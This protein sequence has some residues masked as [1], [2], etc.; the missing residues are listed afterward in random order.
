MVCPNYYPVTCGVGDY[1]MRL[2]QELIDR[3]AEVAVF[4][5]TPAARNPECPAVDVF[6]A[7]GRT[8]L[9]VTMGLY[10]SI[11]AFDPTDL[12]IQ[13]TPHMLR[14]SRFGTLALPA[15]MGQFRG[16]ARRTVIFHELYM[17]WS[18]RPD[19]AVGGVLQR[20]QFGAVLG[21]ADRMFVTTVPRQRHVEGLLRQARRDRDVEVLY[22]GANAPPLPP[23]PSP[24]VRRLGIFSMMGMNRRFDLMVEAFALVKQHHPNGELV[25]IGNLGDDASPLYRTLRGQIARSP[26]AKAIRLTGPIPLGRVAEEVA[27]L[28][29]YLLPD[30]TGAST[31]SSTLPVALGSGVPVVAIRGPETSPDLFVDGESVVF[32]SEMTASSLAEAVLRVLDDPALAARVGRGGRLLYE[33][34]L[35][36]P[37]IAGK[38]LA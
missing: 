14:G 11:A 12:I 28:D 5:H 27:G 33:G 30:V 37:A 35:S 3:G 25:F 32:A 7:A 15:L 34:H 6:G 23:R 31:R 8:P 10:D 24:D 13:Y 36:W 1:S 20:L 16:R 29:V 4:T 17:P 21:A 9:E 38:V 26:A 18:W 19:L 22:V 2:G